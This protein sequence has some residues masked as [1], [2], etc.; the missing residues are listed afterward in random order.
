MYYSRIK[1]FF[2]RCD[3]FHWLYQTN[4]ISNQPENNTGG[5]DRIIKKT[6]TEYK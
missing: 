6:I 1:D 3:N 4:K 2:Q 5:E